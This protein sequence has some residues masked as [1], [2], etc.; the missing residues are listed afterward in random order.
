VLE[1]NR[2]FFNVLLGLF[3]SLEAQYFEKN[4]R[5][6][7]QDEWWLTI[8]L[9]LLSNL[10][11]YISGN[12]SEMTIT[13]ESFIASPEMMTDVEFVS[14]ITEQLDQILNHSRLIGYEDISGIWRSRIGEIDEFCKMW[15]G[16]R[17][18]EISI[19]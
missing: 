7:E 19:H 8:H 18:K 17:D 16:K 10:T 14:W 12:L 13:E 3:T 5:W 2:H 6:L 1:D 9:H 4:G 15:S 11:L